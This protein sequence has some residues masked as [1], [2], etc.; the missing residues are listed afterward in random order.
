MEEK[1]WVSFC[2]STYKRPGI[3]SAQIKLLLSQSFTEFEIIISD[4]D[5]DGSARDIIAF[6]NDDRVH[7]FNNEVNLGMILSFNKS[8][9][10]S[11]TDFI[12]MVTDDDPV[13]PD[14]LKTFY[15]LYKKYP[16][17][18]IYCGFSRTRRP[19]NS[20]EIIPR[21]KFIQEIL[22]PQLTSNLLWSSAVI[23]KVDALRIG[24]IPDYDSPHL[25]D[26]AFMAKV[27][28]VNGGVIL[29]KMYSSLSSHDS[30]FSKFNF[31]YYVE[32]CKGFYNTMIPYCR[33]PAVQPHAEKALLN[34]LG[35]WFIANFFTAKKY[36]TLVKPDQNM[37][38]EISRCANQI[39]QYSFM[40]R[41]RFKYILK[42]LIFS[43][44][45]QAWRLK[46]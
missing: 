18:S 41:F 7:Y 32:G 33:V 44:K 2:I 29:N 8:I 10:R 38:S 46:A 4:N 1:T 22:D 31:H 21:E 34:H 23:R 25:A 3:L 14:F 36:Y 26:H 5:P 17:Y 42:D 6:F 12:V 37:V 45:K 24:L 16:G 39:L 13:D 19:E 35:A 28:S 15:D 43:A 20:I 40:K 11:K 9:E 30:N 27:G